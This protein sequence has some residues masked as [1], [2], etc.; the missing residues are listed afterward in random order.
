MRLGPHTS[1]A[2]GRIDYKQ[3]REISPEAARKAVLEYLRTN[4]GNIY[5][6]ARLF[7]INRAVVYDIMKKNGEGDLKDRSKVPKHQPRK[8]SA[9][10]E[11]KVIEIK[12]KTRLGPERL[13]HYLQQMR[14]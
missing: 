8:T 6:T 10:I 7:G 2:S 5:Q 14:V 13:T 12:N 11:D 3:L 1:L 4:K 9:L